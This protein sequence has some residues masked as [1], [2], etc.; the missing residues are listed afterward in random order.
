VDDETASTPAG[1]E[2]IREQV[3][4]KISVAK[5]ENLLPSD[6]NSQCLNT[7]LESENLLKSDKNDSTGAKSDS[8]KEIQEMG[9]KFDAK[10]NS[11]S[12]NAQNLKDVN[13]SDVTESKSDL[14][15]NSVP[16]VIED[17]KLNEEVQSSEVKSST[18]ATVETKE[19]KSKQQSQLQQ[20]Q[21]QDVQQQQLQQQQQENDDQNEYIDQLPD[22]ETVSNENSFGARQVFTQN[23]PDKSVTDDS[24]TV[25]ESAAQKMISKEKELDETARRE[26]I[27]S[28]Q[29]ETR[30]ESGNEKV[31]KSEGENLESPAK[32]EE[33]QHTTPIPEIVLTFNQ[34]PA[35][36]CSPNIPEIVF[37]LTHDVEDQFGLEKGSK[38][39]VTGDNEVI[40]GSEKDRSQNVE[41]C[42]DEADL[43]KSD[44]SFVKVFCRSIDLTSYDDDVINQA[45]S[46]DVI[47]ALSLAK[48]ILVEEAN[49]TS[50]VT[51][52]KSVETKTVAPENEGLEENQISSTVTEPSETTIESSGNETLAE[53]DVHISNVINEG[54]MAQ[55]TAPNE[56]TE[57]SDAT[58]Q[59]NNLKA[60]IS[61]VSEDLK[62]GS[63][64]A[65]IQ[66][67]TEDLIEKDRAPG[68][69]S[70][71]SEHQTESVD[72]VIDSKQS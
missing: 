70:S 52:E 40:N 57:S 1:A 4:E 44:D 45:S 8:S 65:F 47:T 67:I 7:D 30:S 61:D 11:E 60:T 15:I 49:L 10:S 72:A 13:K 5:T 27:Q 28:A 22:L 55:V 21:Q 32:G 34:E 24:N 26:E 18:T 43:A 25:V 51:T 64:N 36:N 12:S 41:V 53:S 14:H 62:V 31:D 63:T 39:D 20:L 66:E 38:D 69:G 56:I 35:E 19:D 2:I 46:D 33:E 9:I 29:I 42:H 58:L 16:S 68:S 17:S 48:P 6:Q 50:K 59:E 3:G 54:E 23:I 37:T 71:P